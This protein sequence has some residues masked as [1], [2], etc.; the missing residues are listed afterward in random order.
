MNRCVAGWLVGLCAMLV[1]ST[2][3]SEAQT[4][5]PPG[6]AAKEAGEKEPAATPAHKGDDVPMPKLS[7]EL[8]PAKDLPKLFGLCQRPMRTPGLCTNRPSK[9]WSRLPS[10]TSRTGPT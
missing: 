8:I 4:A 1:W 10:P 6:E 3:W 2:G 5:T 9:S 7:F